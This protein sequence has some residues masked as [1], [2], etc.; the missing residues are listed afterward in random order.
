M[1]K[2][3]KNFFRKMFIITDLVT[4]RIHGTLISCQKGFYYINQ[5]STTS[6]QC[7]KII[8]RDESPFTRNYFESIKNAITFSEKQ[9]VG[10][11][12]FHGRFPIIPLLNCPFIA[13]FT[14]KT[15]HFYGPQT[16]HSLIS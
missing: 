10:F 1:I 6:K 12:L 8:T 7:L 16:L 3:E 13:W 9:R 5:A 2:K 15:V 14:Y 4:L 11:A